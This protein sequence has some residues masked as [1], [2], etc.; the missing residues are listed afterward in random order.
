MALSSREG[1]KEENFSGKSKSPA[2]TPQKVRDLLNQGIAGESFSLVGD[3]EANGSPERTSCTSQ[4]PLTSCENA[5][6]ESFFSR[7][8]T[9]TSLKWAGKPPEFSPLQ[10]AKF[11]W[12]NVDCDMLKCSSCQALLCVVL[13][14]TLDVTRYKER[15]T[16]L[17]RSLSIAHEK[18]CFWPD[19]PCPDRFWALPVEDSSALLGGFLDRF[20]S[21]CRLDLQLPSLKHEDLQN[22]C[23]TE[24][25]LSILLH[26]LEDECRQKGRMEDDQLK[27]CAETFSVHIAACIL[28][29][30]GWVSS[31]SLDSLHLPVITCSYCMRNVGLWG[32]QQIECTG[33]EVDSPFGMSS[34]PTHDGRGERFTPI[35]AS[36][37]RMITRSQDMACSLGTE[38]HE[39][40]PSPIGPRKRSRDSHSP[41]PIERGD[42]E[43]TSPLARSN[44]P[45]TRSMGQGEPPG[46]SS[47]VPSSPQRKVR[48]L[49]LCS[50]SSSC[51]V[52]LFRRF[53]SLSGAVFSLFP[54][55]PII[56][57]TK[58]PV[59]STGISIDKDLEA[60]RRDHAAQD[61]VR[62]SEVQPLLGWKVATAATL[63]LH[64]SIRP[65]PME[66]GSGETVAKTPRLTSQFF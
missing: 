13:Q 62:A 35:A 44:R 42:M 8:E 6:K 11:G 65:D 20:R 40:S 37:R 9:F 31:P 27:W 55:T 49:R 12:A 63:C 52:L 47:D 24:E 38:Q 64:A 21:L 58:I 48:R 57:S 51:C 2:V 53:D 39:K 26:L 25:T 36:P 30:C 43:P 1:G 28:A 14:P 56:L 61:L 15:C 59:E 18:F 23:L 46:C 17:K 22:M 10:C 34:T 60:L 5:S 33:T 19:S 45:V 4:P 16:Q 7:V 29:L 41:V 3:E 66:A 54:G 32:F 50:S